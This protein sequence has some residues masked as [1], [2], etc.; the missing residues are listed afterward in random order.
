LKE[1]YANNHLIRNFLYDGFNLT[2]INYYD[3]ILNVLSDEFG[4]ILKIGN[5]EFSYV[6]N[7]LKKVTIFDEFEKRQKEVIFYYNMDNVRYKKVINYYENEKIAKQEEIN[8]ILDNDRIIKE[9]RNNS[10]D[11][12]YTLNTIKGI[13][14]K[15]KNYLVIK[16]ELGDVSNLV[17]DNTVICTYFYSRLVMMEQRYYSPELCRFIQPAD[18]SVLNPSCINGLNLYSYKNNN[19]V[20]FMYSNFTSNTGNVN[21]INYYDKGTQ[22]VSKLEIGGVIEWIDRGRDV[23]DCY[24]EVSQLFNHI[25]YFAKNTFPFMDDMTMLGFSMKDGVLAFN[26]FTWKLGKGDIFG[27]IFSVGYDIYD[28]IN[29]GVSTGGIILGAALTA[30]KT[31]GLIYV[32]KGILYGATAIGSAICPGVGTV[33]G[34]VVGGVI[35]LFVDFSISKWLDKLI[36]EIAK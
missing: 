13:R 8:Y 11:Y 20:C 16:N 26:E 30:G 34:F 2:G 32:N 33:V 10:L 18:V 24:S 27:T 14:Y 9:L 21:Q 28:S 7:N 17:I 5:K 12:I 29:R 3:K 35:C 23:Y 15:N 22:S 19:P 25:T 1:I 31:I 36:D 4:R 6:G